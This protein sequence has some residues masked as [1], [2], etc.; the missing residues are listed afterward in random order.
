MAEITIKGNSYQVKKIPGELALVAAIKLDGDLFASFQKHNDFVEALAK[1][2]KRFDPEE[3][4]VKQDG[5]W[6]LS[7]TFEQ[8]FTIL[9]DLQLIAYKELVTNATENAQLLAEKRA[10]ENLAF[11]TAQRTVFNKCMAAYDEAWTEKVTHSSISKGAEYFK[12]IAEHWTLRYSQETGK[13]KEFIKTQLAQIPNAYKPK[14]SS[15]D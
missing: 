14:Q 7:I 6:V 4:A 13:P 3:I 2:L 15:E 5:E 11:V 8:W 10:V 12:L 1:Q 9:S